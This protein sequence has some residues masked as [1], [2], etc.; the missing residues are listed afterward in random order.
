MESKEY[1]LN[2]FPLIPVYFLTVTPLLTVFYHDVTGSPLFIESKSIFYA[3]FLFYAIRQSKAFFMFI[4]SKPAVVLT[5][6][7]LILNNKGYKI[8]WFDIRTF[9]IT[10][11]AQRGGNHHISFKID[12]AWK[13]IGPIRNP[14]T[15]YYRWLTRNLGDGPFVLDLSVLNDDEDEVLA[16]VRAFYKEYNLIWQVKD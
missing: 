15:R 16:D 10:Q 9:K 8:D 6:E 1:K 2:P 11:S 14:F 3:V 4:T 7:R 13:Y 12:D 5:A